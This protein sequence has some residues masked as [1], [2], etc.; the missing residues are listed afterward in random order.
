MQIL[1]FGF[2]TESMIFPLSFRHRPIGHIRHIYI[3][4]ISIQHSTIRTHLIALR[5]NIHT[6]HQKV[7]PTKYFVWF[8]SCWK[9]ELGSKTLLKMCWGAK[10]VLLPFSLWQSFFEAGSHHQ[11]GNL[12]IINFRCL[13]CQHLFADYDGPLLFWVV[14]EPPFYPLVGPIEGVNTTAHIPK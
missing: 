2:I 5:Q 11:A 12:N 6:C 3:L 4:S 7:G 13:K 14:E 1:K 10:I 8:S 9:L